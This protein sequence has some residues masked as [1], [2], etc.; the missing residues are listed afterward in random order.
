M[1]VEDGGRNLDTITLLEHSYIERTLPD[2]RCIAQH[3][4]RSYGV[5]YG[6]SRNRNGNAVRAS[7][8]IN[9]QPSDT[10]TA[11]GTSRLG[12][13]DLLRVRNSAANLRPNLLTLDRA[14][15]RVAQAV[16]AAQPESG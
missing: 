16:E 7:W 4:T 2:G 1:N 13:A 9:S 11:F 14:R 15:A 3:Q 10:E 12:E 6:S 8:G 5:Y